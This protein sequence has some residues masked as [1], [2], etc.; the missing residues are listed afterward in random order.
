M[1]CL[2]VLSFVFSLVAFSTFSFQDSQVGLQKLSKINTW[3]SLILSE[4]PD[5]YFK[6]NWKLQRS[7]DDKYQIVFQT[8]VDST[9]NWIGFGF[10]VDYDGE[11]D[12]ELH[13][14]NVIP[15]DWFIAWKDSRRRIHHKDCNTLKSTLHFDKSQDYHLITKKTPK[16]L[17][18]TLRRSIDTDD[19]FDAEI[20]TGNMQLLWA[21]GIAQSFS[22]IKP[23]IGYSQKLRR[24]VVFFSEADG[25]DESMTQTSNTAETNHER[26]KQD[27]DSNQVKQKKVNLPSPVL[28]STFAATKKTNC[29]VIIN[30]NSHWYE[31]LKLKQENFLFALIGAAA[32]LAGMI[33]CILACCCARKANTPQSARSKVAFYKVDDYD[34]EQ[35]EFLKEKA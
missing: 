19:P 24:D 14:E 31:I 27:N 28:N 23:S 20:K 18:L 30:N 25:E 1:A 22:R 16:S 8:E 21:Y 13:D 3:R 33:V 7:K 10:P 2:K 11:E 35:V 9:I 12:V 29:T 32:I 15:A 17:N 5:V 6:I 4:S 34:D 26:S